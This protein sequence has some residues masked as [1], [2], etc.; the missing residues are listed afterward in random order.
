LTPLQGLK[1]LLDK[2]IYA[3]GIRHVGESY[4]KLLADHFAAGS[5]DDSD[6]GRFEDYNEIGPVIAASI[7]EFFSNTKTSTS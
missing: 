7:V 6:T 4:A 5:S 1:I 2:F 3:L